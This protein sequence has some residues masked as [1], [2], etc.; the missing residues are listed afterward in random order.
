[1]ILDAV[2]VELASIDANT[3]T[4]G[5][6]ITGFKSIYEADGVNGGVYDWIIE[7]DIGSDGVAAK[8]E[9]GIG[10]WD[11]GA[12]A[13]ARTTAWSTES[14]NA[15]ITVT[16]TSQVIIAPFSRSLHATGNV[17]IG[18]GV[19]DTATFQAALDAAGVGGRVIAPAGY[20][21]ILNGLTID[22]HLAQLVIYG[23]VVV[24][25][26]VGSAPAVGITVSDLVNSAVVE[27]HGRLYGQEELTRPNTND[28]RCVGVRLIGGS[29]RVHINQADSLTS[30]AEIRADLATFNSG[31]NEIYIGFSDQ[32]WAPVRGIGGALF[33]QHTQGTILRGKF[34]AHYAYGIKKDNTTGD[35]TLWDVSPI[36]LDAFGNA[37]LVA[38]IE[39]HAGFSYYRLL[40]DDGDAY[41]IGNAFDTNI[42]GVVL[43]RIA[44]FTKYSNTIEEMAY[45]RLP[46]SIPL[47]SRNADDTGDRSVIR[48]DSSNNVAI[49]GNAVYATTFLPFPGTYAN[50][51]ASPIVG[52]LCT[53]TDSNTATWG[54]T[55]A[56][57]GANF[58]LGFYN[59]TNWTVAAT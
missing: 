29:S 4:L 2:R 26:G 5:P 38:T 41:F 46:N 11:T 54:A 16:G 32:C 43:H 1:V 10:A 15:P 47:F 20:T 40:F 52:M 45:P 30:V 14:A 33:A 7:A 31:G 21:Y 56:G 51:P 44:A 53:F 37:D 35:Q 22:N 25:P 49:G 9:G 48:L 19:D 28:H 36:A 42:R 6:K 59:G 57:G 12:N 50:R 34:W 8:R 58:V 27:I 3:I 55:I 23:D 18:N 39:D 24:P 13:L 17:V